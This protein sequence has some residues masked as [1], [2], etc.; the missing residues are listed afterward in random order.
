MVALQRLSMRSALRGPPSLPVA[1]EAGISGRLELVDTE[2]RLS[3]SGLPRR[4]EGRRVTIAI[5]GALG[6]DPPPVRWAG[7][8]GLVV[9]PRAVSGGAIRI[10]LGEA[11]EPGAVEHHAL[12]EL[13]LF[14]A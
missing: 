7:D 3:L 9:A 8:R 14:P 2:I 1:G 4:Y 12:A 11:T 6:P 5:P 10:A 13:L